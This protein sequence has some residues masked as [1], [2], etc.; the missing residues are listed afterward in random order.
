[1]E[2]VLRRATKFILQEFSSDYKKRLTS[3]FL[4]P[5]MYWF[6]L[7]DILFL[8]ASLKNPSA[9][10]NILDYISFNSTGTRS[11][12]SMKLK[13]NPTRLSANRHFYFNRV[14]RLWNAMPPIDIT[15]SLLTIKRFLFRYLW[16]YFLI[17]FDRDNPCT[18]HYLCPCPSCTDINVNCTYDPSCVPN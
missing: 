6:E 5:L 4:L 11:T 1:M 14:A 8:V 10:F 3:L 9:K 7:H 18:F 15:T 13:I 17:H 12:S 2:R 16:N